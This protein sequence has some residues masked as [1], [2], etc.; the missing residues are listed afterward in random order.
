MDRHAT[1]V[2]RPESAGANSYYF[3]DRRHAP[4]KISRGRGR[5]R[6]ATAGLGFVSFFEKK[7]ITV[8]I[9]CNDS[10]ASP[11]CPRAAPT[12]PLRMP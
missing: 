3:G 10:A 7:I 5:D 9:T 11:G 2:W 1:V 6:K 8:P 4:T 12:A